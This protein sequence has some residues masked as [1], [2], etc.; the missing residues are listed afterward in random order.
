MNQSM[1]PSSRVPTGLLHALTAL[2]SLLAGLPE[3]DDREESLRLVNLAIEGDTEAYRQ[4]NDWLDR[5]LGELRVAQQG[6][7]TVSTARS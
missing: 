5:K 6:E 7:P 2:R 3:G 1:S 4:L